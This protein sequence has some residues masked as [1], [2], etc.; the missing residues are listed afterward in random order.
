MGQ[1]KLLLPWNGQ[2]VIQQ[3]IQAWKSTT[4]NQIVVVVR[5]SDQALAKICAAAGV[6]LVQPTRDP[7]DM[8]ASIQ[9]ALRFIAAE[10]KRRDEPFPDAWLLAP[11]DTPRLSAR[12]IEQLLNEYAAAIVRHSSFSDSS[13]NDSPFNDSPCNDSPSN[14]SPCNTSPQPLILVPTFQGRR[15]HPVLFSWSLVEEVFA[16][17]E[18]DGVN[19]L[20]QR[21]AVRE[22]AMIEPAVIEDLDTPDDYRRLNEGHQ[23]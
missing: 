14:D 23:S 22:L 1:P 12:V 4:V 19:R 16:L 6:D 13:F 15:G 21:H 10:A 3:V 8:K 20:L 11:A 18:Q 9:H 7:P 2:T 5:S 17:G